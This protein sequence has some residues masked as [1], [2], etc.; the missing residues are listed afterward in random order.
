[1]IDPRIDQTDEPA[2]YDHTE[3][4]RRYKETEE[5]I[6]ADLSA[7]LEYVEMTNKESV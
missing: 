2:D 5:T 3:Q 7:Y 4:E 1:M 6:T